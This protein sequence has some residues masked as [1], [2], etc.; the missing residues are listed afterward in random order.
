MSSLMDWISLAAFSPGRA[1]YALGQMAALPEVS[2]DA[3]LAEAVRGATAAADAL[4]E[5]EARWR[6]RQVTSKARGNAAELDAVL[7]RLLGLISQQLQARIGLLPAKD[8]LRLQGEAFLRAQ[9]PGGA[10]PV[11]NLAYE[12]ELRAIKRLLAAFAT[13][14]GR[15]LAEAFEVAGLVR[16]LGEAA[17]KFE[18]E[19][20]SATPETLQFDE[21]RTARADLQHALAWLVARCC[22]TFGS[23]AD[24]PRL[25]RVLDPLADQ[26]ARLRALRATR[27]R[28]VDVNP[29]TGEEPESP[30]GDG[31]LGA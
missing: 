11:V 4:Y 25:A 1:E 13:D 8:A 26:Q 20:R 12:D 6:T 23:P 24:A 31:G 18:Q 15:A 2:G 29:T 22:A 17:P 5:L 27:R 19:L 16:Q 7:D 14:E 30:E 21:V 28:V 10:G 3:A 9:L